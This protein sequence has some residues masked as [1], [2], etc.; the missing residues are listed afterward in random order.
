[1]FVQQSTKLGCIGISNVSITIN[2]INNRRK[3]RSIRFIDTFNIQPERIL[4]SLCEGMGKPITNK[5]LASAFNTAYFKCIPF[6]SLSFN[7]R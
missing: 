5:I 4:L 3:T 2:T 7:C 1:M 6:L